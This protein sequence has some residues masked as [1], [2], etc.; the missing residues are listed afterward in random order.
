MS[1]RDYAMINNRRVK[2][3]VLEPKDPLSSMLPAKHLVHFDHR[4]KVETGDVLQPYAS[5][6]LLLIYHHTNRKTQVFMG[7]IMNEK[8]PHTS[9]YQGI[10]AATKMASGK[11]EESENDIWVMR[12]DADND[13]VKEQVVSRTTYY[14]GT[15]IKVSDKL[16]DRPVT[17]VKKISGIYVAEV[18]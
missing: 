4:W 12:V 11:F 16:D 8:I 6:P 15:E 2:A 5:D 3:V 14:T 7:L 1:I 17:S 18:G 9:Y 10:S 13:L